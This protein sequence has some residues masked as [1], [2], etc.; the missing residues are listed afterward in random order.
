PLDLHSFPTRRSS[1][2]HYLAIHGLK[3]I[4]EQAIEIPRIVAFDDHVL[5]ALHTPAIS[6]VTQDTAQIAVAVMDMLTARIDGKVSENS[7]LI[8]P[9][10]LIARESSIS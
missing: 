1:D 9:Y 10:V 6:V 4:K 8:V 5:F 2:L 3:A 7:G